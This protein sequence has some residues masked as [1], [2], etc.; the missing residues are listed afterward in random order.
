MVHE[1]ISVDT[2]GGLVNAA[3][4]LWEEADVMRGCKQL[5]L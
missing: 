2:L 1:T 5:G 3:R 4:H